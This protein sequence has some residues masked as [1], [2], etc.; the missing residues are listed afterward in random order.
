MNARKIKLSTIIIFVIAIILAIIVGL[1]VIMTINSN[2]KGTTQQGEITSNENW[3]QERFDENNWDS[4]IVAEVNQNVPI[5]QGFTYESGDINT[6]IVVTNEKLG[7]QMIWIP[8]DEKASEIDV[9]SYFANV[10]Y[11][12]IDTDVMKSIKKYGGFFTYLYNNMEY[13]DLKT[14]SKETYAELQGYEN[15]NDNAYSINTHTLYKEELQQIEYYKKNHTGVKCL[16]DVTGVTLE[17]YSTIY[18]DET[19][20]KTSE[21]Q[22]NPIKYATT[23]NASANK[24]A[25]V[26]MLSTSAYASEVPIPLGYKY[27]V[28]ENGIVSIQD[29]NNKNL[30]YIWVPLTKEG[31]AT[32]KTEL[33]KLYENWS[34]L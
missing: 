30:I 5:P 34:S 22:T 4:T 21:L 33:K 27:S 18:V 6:G 31:L 2:K 12:E 8:Y 9:S 29:E 16:L 7:I 25:N 13:T 19:T 1:V 17:P 24:K 3:D 23:R 32:S 15:L 10:D 14:I 20:V 11:E 26:Y 28:D